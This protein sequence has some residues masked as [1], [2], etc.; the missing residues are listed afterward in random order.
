MAKSKKNCNLKFSW[1][2]NLIYPLQFILWTTLRRIDTTL[3][4]SEFN[5]STSL[6]FT[7]VMFAS[8]FFAGLLLFL[9]QRR[10]INKTKKK[11]NTKDLLIYQE[12]RLSRP[13]RPLKIFFLLFM[14]SYFDFISFIMLSNYIPQYENA[15]GSLEKRIEGMLTISSALFFYYILRFPIYKHQFY[16]LIVIGIC[17][18]TVIGTEFGFQDFSDNFTYIDLIKKIALIFVEHIF[19]SFL[20]SSEKYVLEYDHVFYATALAIEGFF[21]FITIMILS[22][23]DS[24]YIAQVSQI[25]QEN[26]G[27]KF[28]FFIFLIFGYF[29]LSGGTNAFRVL[30]NKKYSPTSKSLVDYLL[31]PIYLIIDYIFKR[32][33]TRNGEKDP[34]YFIFNLLLSIMVVLCGCVYNEVIILFCCGLEGETYDQISYRSNKNYVQAVYELNTIDEIP[35]ILE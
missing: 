26:S 13:D 19:N 2:P 10:N 21:G 23:S 15:S 9:Y 33:F 25:Y 1:R 31:T 18:I 7:I 17:L 11:E 16:S 8:E 6:L 12:N 24:S 28:A 20:D 34:F 5:F 29:V 14:T 4:E 22:I 3:L 30:T 32:D 35:I 27:G